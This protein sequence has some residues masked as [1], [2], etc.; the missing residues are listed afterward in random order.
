MTIQHY[1]VVTIFH[2]DCEKY[3]ILLTVWIHSLNICEI[4]QWK[5]V[6]VN[7]GV[8]HDCFK[9]NSHNRLSNYQIDIL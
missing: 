3:H 8:T 1:S 7:Q 9:K 2:N 6:S 4:Q 5:G